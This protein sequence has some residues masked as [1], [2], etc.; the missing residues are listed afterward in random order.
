MSNQ[1][2][3]AE[4]L[5]QIAQDKPQDGDK[6]MSNDDIKVTDTSGE[7][8]Q[9]GVDEDQIEKQDNNSQHKAARTENSQQTKWTKSINY[10][11]INPSGRIIK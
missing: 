7:F 10:Q 11:S 3:A 2:D 9:L 6:A 1:T 4:L 8:V 5:E